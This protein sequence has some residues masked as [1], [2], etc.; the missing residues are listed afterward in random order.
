M[1]LL[2]GALMAE[3]SQSVGAADFGNPQFTHGLEALVESIDREANLTDAGIEAQRQRILGLLA[4][5]LRVEQ[6]LAEHP[7]IRDE[8]IHAPI[9]IVG[10]P[11]TG[12]TMTHRL[13][14]SDPAHTAMLWWEGR[15][16][17]MLPGEKRGEPHRRRALGKA[18]VEAV[19]AA[20]PEAMDIHPWDFEGADEEV[21]LLEHSFHSSVPESFMHLPSYSGWVEAQDHVP[22]YQDLSALLKYLQW[23]TPTRAGKRWVL[24]SPHHLGYLDALLAVFPD[25][26]IIQTHR[27][28]MQTVPSFCSMCANLARPLTQQPDVRA[29][30]AHW[31][32]KL[33]RNLTACMETSMRKPDS[34]LDLHF[35]EMV[36]DPI[37]QM[38]R[39]YAFAGKRLGARAEAAMRAYRQDD[40]HQADAHSYSLADYGLSEAQ[41]D[42]LFHDYVDRYGL[43]A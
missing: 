32:R 43:L 34:F 35:R 20:S 12:S 30:G 2:A 13:L 38:T 40:A 5:R 25:A 1:T 10:L 23:Q 21:L 19:V 8:P 22:V 24:K 31:V 29:I 9:V 18:E 36:L 28:P 17:A 37:A 27:H 3:A 11:R 41:I 4:N 14:A 39:V 33:S 42:A 6:A 26:K 16:P 15:H 7:E